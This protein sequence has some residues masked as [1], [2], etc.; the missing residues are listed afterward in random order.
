MENKKKSRF[1]G[2]TCLVVAIFVLSMI[3]M[4]GL[5][6][7]QVPLLLPRHLS[8]LWGIVTM[9]FVHG[10]FWHLLSNIITLGVFAFVISINGNR[11]FWVTTVFI[12][13]STGALVWLFGRGV[14]HV[15]ASGLVFGYFGFLMA[16]LFYSPTLK[17][18]LLTVP[19]AIF[20]GGMTWGVL[21][22]GNQ[23]SWE[24][25]LFGLLAGVFAA[26]SFY[27]GAP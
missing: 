12:L 9:P 5:L 18:F 15:G 11:Y 19:I 16:R 26:R 23:I 14:Y 1:Y 25:H 24:S 6:P 21:P 20:Y 17:Y 2:A 10:D 8:G 22:Q 4:L 3:E 13:L 7:F 27:K